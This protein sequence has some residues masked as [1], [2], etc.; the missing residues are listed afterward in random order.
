MYNRRKSRVVSVGGV[1]VGGDNPIS[2]QSMANTDTRDIAATVAQIRALEAEGCEIAR[3]AVLDEAAARC[4]PDIK[5]QI[6]IPIVADI[7]FDYRLA[8]LSMEYGIDKLRINPG[9]IGGEENVRAVAEMAKRK[10]IPIRVGV[11][12]GSLSKAILAKYGKVTAEGLAESALE[13]IAMLEKYGFDNIILSIKASNIPLTVATHEIIADK[14]DYPLHIGITEAGPKTAGVIK[15]AAGAAA[16]LTRGIGDTL[17]VSLTDDPISEIICAKRILQ[18]LGLRN[19]DPEII[20]CPS[21]GRCKVDLIAM[22]HEV[23]KRLEG[24][25]KYL[26]IAV[27]GC[28]VNGPGEAREAD[29]GIACGK[30]SGLIFKGGEIVRRIPA[31]LLVD[32]L[33]E[34]LRN[35]GVVNV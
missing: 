15:S 18:A 27:M 17:R 4:L 26:K 35:M 10:N 16:L 30:A 33:M 8:I 29:I 24:I 5:R 12:G 34:E 2:I 1:K 6:S 14:I 21:C 23:E 20:S 7:H 22:T 13:N 31:G 25:S 32:A 19:F 28:E 3:V 9:N 11:N